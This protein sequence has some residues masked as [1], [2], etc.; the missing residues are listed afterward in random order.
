MRVIAVIPARG[1]SKRLPRKNILP[2]AGNPA[3]SYPIKAALNSELF[4]SVVVST[5]D[6]EIK[7]IALDSGASVCDRSVTLA[8]DRSTVAEVCL[9]TI[10]QQAQEPNMFCCIYATAVLLSDR[11]LIDSFHHFNGDPQANYLMGVSRFNFPPVQALRSD[12]DGCLSYL[13]PEFVGVQ[14]QFFPNLLVSNGT[15]VWTTTGKFQKEKTFYGS[16]L[17]GFVVPEHEVIDIDTQ[18]DFEVAKRMMRSQSSDV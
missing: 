6:S 2:L 1:G 15:F 3:L 11:T 8:Q 16:R 7:D 17:K 13:W 10:K 14:S 5:E 4:D 9:D 18:E 12:D